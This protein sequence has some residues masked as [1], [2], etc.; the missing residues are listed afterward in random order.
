M[1]WKYCGFF[2]P[3]SANMNAST[4]RNLTTIAW[5][6]FLIWEKRNADSK[7]SGTLDW[8]SLMGDDRKKL[9]REL[10]KRLA[11]YNCLQKTHATRLFN[12]GR[13]FEDVYFNYISLWEPL[14]T[15]LFKHRGGKKH[16]P[17]MM[18]HTKE[19]QSQWWSSWGDMHWIQ[20]GSSEAQRATAL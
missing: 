12:Y 9:L 4:N 15:V 20:I 10:P 11:S 16:W 1:P 7:G 14:S 19:E 2:R 5:K 3:L 8:T 18:H 6:N 13:A 17:C